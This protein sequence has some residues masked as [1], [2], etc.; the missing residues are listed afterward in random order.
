[1]PYL[2][3][4]INSAGW[5]LYN[6]STSIN[7]IQWWVMPRNAWHWHT[8][9]RLNA[10]MNLQQ[11]GSILHICLVIYVA[12]DGFPSYL[13]QITNSMGEGFDR[14]GIYSEY[15]HF[16]QRLMTHCLTVQGI[17]YLIWFTLTLLQWFLT[18]IL[19]MFTFVV[20]MFILWHCSW[21]M[22]SIFAS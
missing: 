21:L 17:G 7:S 22:I 18:N 9:I 15:R 1:M 13:T 5:F 16:T 3:G 11:N 4:K 2:L 6:L 19:T 14:V 12:L 20:Y 8:H 10:Y